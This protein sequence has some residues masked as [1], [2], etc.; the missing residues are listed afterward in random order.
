MILGL[1]SYN[2]LE[3]PAYVLCKPNNDRIGVLYCTEKKHTIKFND[4]DEISFTTYLN[5]DGK[6]NSLYEKVN[7]L[8]HI[9]LPDI[10]RFVIGDISI[11]SE[12][13]QHEYK[14]CTAI[15]EEVLLAQ[16]YLELFTIN[17]GT[18][19]S[20]DGVSFCNLLQ[21]NQSLLHLVLEK[22]PDWTIGHIDNELYTMQRC[23]EVDRQ[24]VYSF[25]TTDVS[26]AFEC[27]FEFDTINYKIN[28][29]KEKNV[30]EDTNIHISYS[31]LAK[32]VSI[33]S[34]TDDIKTCL[35]LIGADDLNVREVNMGYDSIYNI[36]YFHS[37]EYMSQ[38]L[39]DAFSTWKELWNSK[40]DDYEELVV[41]YQKF[42]TDIH[43]LE[44]VKMP[45]DPESKD[46]TLYGLNPLKEKLAANEQ[47]QAVMIKAGQGET[48]HRDYKTIYLPCYN[49]IQALKAQITVVE[50]EITELKEKQDV[51][52]KQMREIADLVDMKNN[53]TQEQLNEL[54]KYIREDELSSDNYVVT[55]IMTDSERMDMLH[56]LLKYGQ[57]E[58]AKKSVPTLDFSM[59]MLNIYA[60]P[61]FQK[62]V[63]KFYPGNYIYVTLRDD[64]SA[65]LRLLTM[66]INY[67]DKND[68]SVTFGN[69]AKLK[70]NK[71]FQ[72][73][74]KALNLASAAATSVSFNSSSWN[75]ANKNSTAISDALQS[76]LLSA[77]QRLETTESDVIID[78]RGITIKNNPNSKYANDVIFLGGGQIVFSDDGLKTIKTALGR[79]QYTKS[80]TTYDD[81][82]LLAQFVIAGFIGGSVI[83]GNEINNGNGTFKVDPNGNLIATSATIKGTIKADEGY[84][85]GEN[86][87]TIKTGKMY[88]GSKSTFSSANAG[89]YIGTD[90][91]S[92]GKN[93]PFKVDSDG[94]LTAKSGTIGGAKISGNSISS[95]NW[96]L[97]SS[98]V[99]SLKGAYING[100]AVNSS[101]GSIGYNGTN[102]WGNFS[103][104]SYYGSSASSPFSGGCVSHIQSISADYIY[105][106]YLKAIKADINELESDYVTV[107]KKL[108]AAEA[109][110]SSLEAD[111]VNVNG[112][113]TATEAEIGTLNATTANIKGDLNAV[114]AQIGDL[115]ITSG[116][117]HIAGMLVTPSSY[118]DAD[119]NTLHYLKWH[120]S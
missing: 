20:I 89:V 70:G 26:K 74:T 51:V 108:T 18:T 92:L 65:K 8:M 1:D 28:V 55:D 48:T 24:D 3:T 80:G 90:G 77:G 25:L 95:T 66:D 19:E 117:F 91:I 75:S 59:D 86:G 22:C 105:A 115:S 6:A 81:F 2:N 56:D 85:G 52:G 31:N 79:V 76:G 30:G 106:N 21:P 83:E 61:E 99:A 40:V 119:G 111:V 39:Y 10:G 102:T 11:Q 120:Y 87:F 64:Y 82:G 118:I 35:K 12:G 47:K 36:D 67:L 113:I 43:H 78:N 109:D 58:L 9:E 4:Y 46:W 15:S 84:I 5:I 100:V 34:S 50:S 53:F 13:T 73:V 14:E 49:E 96:T 72:D 60:I 88:S 98:G 29:Y 57:E 110:I 42:Y 101:F 27:I 97:N 45:E 32:N 107:N 103:G 93:S 114:E 69:I 94:N 33:S 16:K 112:R 54:T 62:N 44:S 68:F 71:L 63:D 7:E 116:G 41:Q 23:F 104:N 38:G 17:M 37:L